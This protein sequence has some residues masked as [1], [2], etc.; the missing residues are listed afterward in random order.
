[1]AVAS[2][3]SILKVKIVQ[4]ES[5]PLCQLPKSQLLYSMSN[6]KLMS[7]LYTLPHTSARAW[8]QGNSDIDILR[9]DLLGVDIMELPFWEL[10]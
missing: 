1:M 7:A 2:H 9:I 5:V 6:P 8:G 3:F 10:I 4:C